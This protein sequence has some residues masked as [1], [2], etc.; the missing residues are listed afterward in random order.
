MGSAVWQPRP[1]GPWRRPCVVHRWQALPQGGEPG[2]RRGGSLTFGSGDR[3][4]RPGRC[5]RNE[6]YA[7]LEGCFR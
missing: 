7:H 3:R 6:S 2:R 1:R 4:Q 5:L